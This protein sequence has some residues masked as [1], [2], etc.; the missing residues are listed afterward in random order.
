MYD[1]THALL[2]Q[3]RACVFLL[4]L[5]CLLFSLCAFCLLGGAHSFE[6]RLN[7]MLSANR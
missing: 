2:L 3:G 5:P 1:A 6:M 7:Q 4:A